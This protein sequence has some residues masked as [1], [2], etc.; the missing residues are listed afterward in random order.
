MR[1]CLNLAPGQACPSLLA[2]P[3]AGKHK[4]LSILTCKVRV[5]VS[6]Y[7]RYPGKCPGCFP[8]SKPKR[9]IA[10]YPQSVACAGSSSV[11]SVVSACLH[12]RCH[13]VIRRSL[14]Q[15][16]TKVSWRFGSAANALHRSQLAPGRASTSASGF[17]V[18]A[19]ATLL[20]IGWGATDGTADVRGILRNADCCVAIER[21]CA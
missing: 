7:V 12:R 6:T 8:K 1:S 19:V 16:F 15:S 9:V 21:I 18:P 20:E 4:R 3:L 10:T 14:A 2:V 13:R 17:A 11:S 5:Y